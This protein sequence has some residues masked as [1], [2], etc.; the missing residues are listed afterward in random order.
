[1]GELPMGGWRGT[2]QVGGNEIA[3][4]QGRIRR[5]QSG[6]VYGAF[7]QWIYVIEFVPRFYSKVDAKDVIQPS[8]VAASTPVLNVVTWYL[9]LL[10]I[11]EDLHLTL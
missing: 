6:T 11:T 8:I 9:P 2:S 7:H 3:T 5:T 10:N 4:W 1:M